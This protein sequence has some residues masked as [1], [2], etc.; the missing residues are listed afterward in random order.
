MDLKRQIRAYITDNLLFSE[1]GIEYDDDASFLAKGLID[2]MGVMELVMYVGT[3][4][5]ICVDPREVTPENFDSVNRLSAYIE[6]KQGRL[7]EVAAG[8]R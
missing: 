8:T 4:F 7:H 6:G 3:D 5:G 2:S 1:D